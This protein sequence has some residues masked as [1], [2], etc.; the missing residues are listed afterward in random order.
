M[1]LKIG[2][3][4]F[5]QVQIP[6]LWGKRAVLQD[7]DGAVSVIYLG[8]DQAVLEVL[9]DKPAPGVE[10]VPIDEGF[11]VL[12]EGQPAYSYIADS[13]TLRSS[14]DDLPE[15]ELGEDALRIGTSFF[16]AN[17]VIGSPVGLVISPDGIG[18][19]APLPPG[20]AELVV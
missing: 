10:Y 13:K 2:S 8:G 14:T 12:H 18:L 5:E 11:E 16:Q 6:M 3:N 17:M 9:A 1:K 19:G 7:D 15:V 20:L 4:V